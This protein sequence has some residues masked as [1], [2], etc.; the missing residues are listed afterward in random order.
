MAKFGERLASV[1]F[2]G[3]GA[4]LLGRRI[5]QKQSDSMLG[6]GEPFEKKYKQSS[7]VAKKINDLV[8]DGRIIYVYFDFA[9]RFFIVSTNIKEEIGSL[10]LIQKITPTSHGVL[11]GFHVDNWRIKK[12]DEIYK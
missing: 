8:K 7:A 5:G 2:L 6:V 1:F 10:Y 4:F 12:E 9:D 11:K 3:L